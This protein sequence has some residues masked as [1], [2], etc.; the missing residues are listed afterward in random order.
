VALHADL[1]P[2]PV[3]SLSVAVNKDIPS[4]T[5]N[6]EPPGNVQGFEELTK[7]HIRYKPFG[8]KDYVE[9]TVTGS[10]TSIDLSHGSG[11]VP[12]KN[13]HFQVCAQSCCCKGEWKEVTAF[14][15]KYCPH[16]TV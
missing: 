15:G 11:L 10:T 13:Y 3:Q 7:Y 4:V 5:L 14:Y 9:T 16:L 8:D 12:L 6:W 1:I 2:D